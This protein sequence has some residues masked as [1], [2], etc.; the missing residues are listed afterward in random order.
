MPFSLPSGTTSDG[1]HI[2]PVQELHSGG[3]AP[4]SKF[5]KTLTPEGKCGGSHVVFSVT[6]M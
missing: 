1:H 4:D 3:A 6:S 2:A 5:E